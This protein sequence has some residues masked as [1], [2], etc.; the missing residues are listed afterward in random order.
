MSTEVSISCKYES[1]NT[2]IKINDPEL[3][4]EVFLSQITPDF[5]GQV[6]VEIFERIGFEW[7]KL[8]VNGNTTQEY[9]DQRRFVLEHKIDPEMTNTW[10]YQSSQTGWYCAYKPLS[11]KQYAMFLAIDSTEEIIDEDYIQ[12]LFGFY[13]HQLCSLEGTYRDNLTGLY[14]R[15]AFDL[16][17]ASLL[18]KQPFSRRKNLSTPSVYVMLDIDHFKQINDNHGHLYGDEVLG[19]ISK[20]MIDSFREYDL[21]FRYGGEEFAA[22]LMD[23]DD[24]ICN[25]VLNRFRKNVETYEFPKQDKVTVSIGYTDFNTDLNLEQIIDQADSALYYSK[26]HGRNAIHRYQSLL[27]KSLISAT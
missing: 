15:K 5:S 24:K 11:S 22:V 7:N 9:D 20:L 19:I 17:M 13:C 10:F 18:N 27:E 12:L 14:N 21:L 1:F 2:L 3:L 26:K 16:R 4:L 6:N 25:Q 23:I 8:L